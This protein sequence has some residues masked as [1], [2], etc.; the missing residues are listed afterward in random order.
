ME[1]FQ[2]VDF[3]ET[4]NSHVDEFLE[5]FK[6][7]KA[8]DLGLDPRAYYGPIRVS[9]GAIVIEGNT[10]S[11][12]YYGGFEY[13]DASDRKVIGD[14]TFYM[15][16]EEDSRVRNHLARIFPELDTDREEDDED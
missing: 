4:I 15:V 12:D 1:N 2:I 16:G 8:A 7:V 6:K 5:G 9:P 13:V 10:R 3:L 11:M 14:Y